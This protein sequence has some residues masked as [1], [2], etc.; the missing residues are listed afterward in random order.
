MD[1]VTK[2]SRKT[3]MEGGLRQVQ[4]APKPVEALQETV[5]RQRELSANASVQNPKMA[6]SITRILERSPERNTDTKDAMAEAAIAAAA[7]AYAQSSAAAF[8]NF[9][10]GSTFN[11]RMK[12]HPTIKLGHWGWNGSTEPYEQSMSPGLPPGYSGV[13]HTGRA[14]VPHGVAAQTNGNINSYGV[15][16]VPPGTSTN[17]WTNINKKMVYDVKSPYGPGYL[18]EDWEELS[19]PPSQNPAYA[20]TTRKVIKLDERGFPISS[21]ETI[22]T[23]AP[24]NKAGNLPVS[25]TFRLASPTPLED[26]ESEKQNTST[27][28]APAANGS[29]QSAQQR[30]HPPPKPPG[31]MPAVTAPFYKTLNTHTD[32]TGRVHYASAPLV[33]PASVDQDFSLNFEQPKHQSVS[34]PVTLNLRSRDPRRQLQ[35]GYTEVE[36]S[37]HQSTG[38]VKYPW[39]PAIQN[40]DRKRE[41]EDY[42]SVAEPS[43]RLKVSGSSNEVQNLDLSVGASAMG[44]WLEEGAVISPGHENNG[45]QAMDIDL[46]SPTPPDR[47]QN[48]NDE[49]AG[50]NMK[51]IEIR[52]EN[53]PS[54]M[55]GPG[56]A[57]S[58]RN[59]QPSDIFN[60]PTKAETQV[61]EEVLGKPENFWM[62]IIVRI[63]DAAFAFYFVSLQFFIELYNC[64][65]PEFLYKS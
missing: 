32:E 29:T 53:G 25:V 30:L 45:V 37:L 7:L 52:S 4:A 14:F 62:T 57:T 5:V 8:A 55:V 39:S 12:D 6:T 41:G 10:H 16:A 50:I 64:P 51:K 56:V 20:F 28:A 48:L 1:H 2:T 59:R 36:V 63:R 44:G 17:G 49:L 60:N 43:K 58:M 22:N 31:I 23:V 33:T 24:Q 46:D 35:S 21:S 54:E 26:D 61:V 40:L 19:P 11:Q 3:R 15:G 47:K 65:K 38:Q 13:S 9:S 18:E 34:G 27:S 42:S